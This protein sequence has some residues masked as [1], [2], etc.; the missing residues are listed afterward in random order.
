MRWERQIIHPLCRVLGAA[1]P[2]VNLIEALLNW[3]DQIS[4]ER[5][6]GHDLAGSD[7]YRYGF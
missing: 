2:L 1:K 5:D 3:H 4:E 7:Y 6:H